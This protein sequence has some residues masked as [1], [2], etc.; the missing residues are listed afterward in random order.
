MNKAAMGSFLPNEGRFGGAETSEHGDVC[1]GR[2]VDEHVSSTAGGLDTVWDSVEDDDNLVSDN[3]VVMLGLV[4][5]IGRRIDTLVTVTRLPGRVELD[6]AVDVV[7]CSAGLILAPDE[8]ARQ[9][10]VVCIGG[11]RRVP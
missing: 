11:I 2:V 10:F 7:G 9:V 1:V 3:T 8:V 4:L 5:A 6:E